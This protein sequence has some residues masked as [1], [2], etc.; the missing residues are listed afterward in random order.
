MAKVRLLL[1]RLILVLP[2]AYF[3]ILLAY[4]RSVFLVPKES[5]H[6]FKFSLGGPAAA[7]PEKLCRWFGDPLQAQ[8]VVAIIKPSNV[9]RNA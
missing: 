8:Q 9:K 6:R 4:T 5:D 2:N 3:V 1:L 7:V